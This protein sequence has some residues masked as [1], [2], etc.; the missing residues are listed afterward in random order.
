MGFVLARDLV[1]YFE[2]RLEGP[3]IREYCGWCVN[4]VIPVEGEPP[5]KEKVNGR[6]IT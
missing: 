1:A 5:Y 2:G 6:P 4:K 3:K